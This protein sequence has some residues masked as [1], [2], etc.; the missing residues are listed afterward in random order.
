M[1][2][3]LCYPATLPGQRAKYGLQPLGV[4]YIAALLRREGF[5][6][7]VID[8]DID[9]LS[10]QET[11]S[12]ILQTEPDLVGFSL[13]TPQL[14]TALAC[15]TLIKR[16][17]PDLPIVLGG[18]HIDSTKDD[19]FSMADCFDFAIH[20]EGEWS[21][22]EVCRNLQSQGAA[23]L[24]GCL[25]GVPNVLYR[26]GDGRVVVNPARPF[27]MEL[28]SL[29]SVDYDLVDVSKYAIPTMSGRYVISMML[30]RGCP[31]RCTFC[32]APITMGKKLRFWSIDRVIRD[33]ADCRAKYGARHFVF[34]DSTFTANR[35][36]AEEFCR[37]L[38]R[39]GLDIRFRC[40]TRANLVPQPL[41]ETMRRA[42]CDMIN[43][44]VESGHPEILSRIKKEVDL[45]RVRDAFERCRALGIRTYA[46]FLVGA[47]GETEETMRTTIDFAR[48]IRPTLAAFNVATAY[49]GTPMYDEAVAAGVATPRWWA[50]QRWDSQRHSP[51]QVRWGWTAAGALHFQ[52]FDPEYWQRRAT[53]AFYFRSRFICDTLGFTVRHPYFLRHLWTLGTELLP[54]YRLRNLLPGLGRVK[55]DERPQ[56]LQKC[57]SLP[58]PGY[59][60]RSRMW[61]PPA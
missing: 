55:E 13:M 29:P 8:A 52:D 20:G 12:H 32:D 56:L 38:I 58:N 48:S 49:P 21:L 19:V 47:P 11:V 17:R 46:T 16:Q 4:L 57:P 30:S 61:S 3:T 45:D 26:T 40:N 10:L 31:F 2:V 53:R 35:K 42:G 34:K 18:A 43:F 60:A 6:T 54:V 39:S 51:F 15:S 9:G 25:Q 1:R 14:M 23:D 59:R 50:A 5:D 41:L 24:V 28:D 37:A 7:Q 22:L 44:G 33:I 36:W 27:Q